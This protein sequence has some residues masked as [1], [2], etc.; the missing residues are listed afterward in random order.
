MPAAQLEKETVGARS[1]IAECGIPEGDIVG[2]RA[3][4]LETDIAL[5]KELYTNGFLYER[6][7]SVCVC[8]W[9]WWWWWGGVGVGGGVGGAAGGRRGG[10]EGGA[11]RSTALHERCDSKGGDDTTGW[12]AARF[13]PSAAAPSPLR[14]SRLFW[15]IRSALRI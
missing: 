1:Q 2:F 4:Y 11:P 3:P 9:W 12:P 14:C 10:G 8:V 13:G 7:G 15:H 5:R 6:C